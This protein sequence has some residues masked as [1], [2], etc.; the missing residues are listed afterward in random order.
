[1]EW[2]IWGFGSLLALAL[3]II[4]VA[5]WRSLVRDRHEPNLGPQRMS[6]A[7]RAARRSMPRGVPKSR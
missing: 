4:A 1:M 2:V 7:R 5:A 6:D 3:M